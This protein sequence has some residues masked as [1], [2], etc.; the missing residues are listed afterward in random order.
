[1]ERSNEGRY[2]KQMVKSECEYKRRTL[3]EDIKELRKFVS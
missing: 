1:V 3:R 2:T